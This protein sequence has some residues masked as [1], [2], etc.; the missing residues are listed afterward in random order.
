M[1]LNLALPNCFYFPNRANPSSLAYLTLT[2]AS[3]T[4]RPPVRSCALGWFP[5]LQGAYALTWE[6]LLGIQ[7]GPQN[8][9]PSIGS[10]LGY[11]QEHWAHTLL[12]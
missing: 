5:W 4:T 6:A 12:C 7:L 1:L 2:R 3:G 9:V 11:M 10:S 8:S